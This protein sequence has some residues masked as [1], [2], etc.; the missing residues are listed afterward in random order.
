MGKHVARREFSEL[1]INDEWNLNYQIKF[2]MNGLLHWFFLLEALWHPMLIATNDTLSATI[3]SI[4]L[5]EK[6]W[7]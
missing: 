5:L 2:L 4:S 6:N 3:F 1:G 7:F